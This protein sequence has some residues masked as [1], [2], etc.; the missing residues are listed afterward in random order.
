MTEAQR[1][2]IGV[3]GVVV[4]AAL[5]VFGVFAAHFTGL[6][7][8]NNV[9]QEIYPHIPRCAWFET[10][11]CWVIPMASK[12]VAFI[13]SQ[14]ALGAVVF[15]WIWER[16]S[17]WARATV[18]AFL[19]TLEGIILF[20]IVANEWLGLAQGTLAWTEQ[21]ILVT[22]PKW[23]VLNNDLHIS[24]GVL[25]DMIVAGYATTLLIALAVGVYQLQEHE[26]K[27]DQPKPQ[28]VSGY[29]R[30]LVKGDR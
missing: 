10:G 23:I 2:R 22:I 30:P 16:P 18:G 6:S 7:E 25:K 9:G 15:G 13:G 28:V 1:Q 14:I 12:M 17:T 29:G 5:F 4:G 19:F 8:T 24:F 20:G 27:A 21:K 3:I 11:A 26:K